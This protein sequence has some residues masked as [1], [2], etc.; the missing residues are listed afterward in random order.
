[1]QAVTI[2][3]TQGAKLRGKPSTIGIPDLKPIRYATRSTP[4]EWQSDC[5]IRTASCEAVWWNKFWN[6]EIHGW[7]RSYFQKKTGG[8]M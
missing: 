2:T 7:F 1:M 5:F 3:K 8:I 4:L 6:K